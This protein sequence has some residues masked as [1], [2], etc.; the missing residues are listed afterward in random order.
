MKREEM[1]NFG[2]T[3]EKE[4]TERVERQQRHRR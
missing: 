4:Q 3:K 1:G 2:G